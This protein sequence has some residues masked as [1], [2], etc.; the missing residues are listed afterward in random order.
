MSKKKSNLAKGQDSYDATL[1][2]SLVAFF[3]RNVTPYPTEVGGPKFD[4]VPVTQRKD[5]M[6]NAA[7]MHAEQ[8]YNRIT[9]LMKVLAKQ[10]EELKRRLD[11]TDMV[12]AAE[13]QF[14]PAHGQTY[15]L[16]YDYKINNTRLNHHGPDDWTTGKPEHY[17]YI[18]QVKWLG[19][20]T[21]AEVTTQKS[22]DNTQQF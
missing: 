17:E 22:D 10:A 8:E 16:I 15:W 12:H 13:Y 3:N 1:D 7:R 4:L 20:Y 11:I 2:N 19:D 6:L 9:D 21:W 18:T 5:I 14:Q